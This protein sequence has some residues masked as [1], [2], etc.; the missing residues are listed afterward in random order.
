MDSEIFSR[1]RPADHSAAA[2]RDALAAVEVECTDATH[3]AGAL[4][5]ERARLLLTATT[6]AIAT[7]ET[8]IREIATDLEQLAAIAD[9]L[10][11]I[12]RA[13]EER[14]SGV[15]HAQQVREAAEA[16]GVSGSGAG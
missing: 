5:A 3:R 4:T 8:A 9:A 15:A 11:P 13:A 12:L 7:V 16:I 10:L 6:A 1:L 2:I 14:E